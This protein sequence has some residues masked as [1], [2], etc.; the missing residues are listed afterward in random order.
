TILVSGEQTVVLDAEAA[1]RVGTFADVRQGVDLVVVHHVACVVADLDP[2]V[3]HR[4][5]DLGQGRARA[6]VAAVLFDDDK[7][8]VV[9]RHRSDLLEVPGPNLGIVAF[10]PAHRQYLANPCR[11]R[12]AHTPLERLGVLGRR[13]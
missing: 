13:T 2:V 7:H 11:G 12:L 5:D 10:G 3:V 4:A 8:S 6:G 9:P 1:H